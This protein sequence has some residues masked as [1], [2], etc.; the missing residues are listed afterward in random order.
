MIADPDES[1]WWIQVNQDWWR[2]SGVPQSLE[3]LQNISVLNHFFKLES[4][5]VKQEVLYFD[6]MITLLKAFLRKSYIP[7]FF[8]DDN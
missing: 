7:C 4:Q 6:N 8:I 2:R 3:H 1:D 5:I